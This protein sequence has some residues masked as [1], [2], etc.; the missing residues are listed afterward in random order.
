MI[1]NSVPT[2]AICMSSCLLI[3]YDHSVCSYRCFAVH[4]CCISAYCISAYQ[5]LT[6]PG[7]VSG[8]RWWWLPVYARNLCARIDGFE[9]F[10]YRVGLYRGA[11]VHAY[12]MSAYRGLTVAGL[13]DRSPLV[14]AASLCT[15]A[16]RSHRFE[17]HQLLRS[18]FHNTVLG[19]HSLCTWVCLCYCNT[20]LFLCV[21][22]F[23][24]CFPL[25]LF[26]VKTVYDS[27]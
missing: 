8:I 15:G 3:V 22:P 2:P 25:F 18:R 7:F 21:G 23:V 17:T 9:L 4:A 12:C 11:T 13:S 1:C 10:A 6:V 20:L 14:V 24:S 5:A 16:L 19:D 26:L 27:I